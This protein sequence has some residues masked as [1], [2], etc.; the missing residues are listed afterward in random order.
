MDAMGR[1]GR[2]ADG[3]EVMDAFD[4]MSLPAECAAQCNLFVETG[5]VV[6]LWRAWQLARSVPMDDHI[7][8]R[9]MEYIAPHLDAM[10][11]QSETGKA[12]TKAT[13]AERRLDVLDYYDK[14]K[15]W[16]SRPAS[17]QTEEGIYRFIAQRR[18]LSAKAVK[19]H[20]M[21]RRKPR[22]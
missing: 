11:Q 20:V 5:N 19:N 18:G 22:R 13:D 6:H 12:T 1:S 4:R 15:R 8:M 16:E 2:G 3:G 21:A 10:V 9:C 17:L 7:F 14:L